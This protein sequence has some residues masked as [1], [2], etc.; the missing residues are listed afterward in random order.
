LETE[1]Q[2]S[3]SAG[4]NGEAIEKASTNVIA[5]TG[6]WLSSLQKRARVIVELALAEARLA[7]VS[8][9]WIV[10]MAVFAIAFVFIGW[11]MLAVAV[12][13][14]LVN[15]GVPLWG[16]ALG[17]ALLHIAGAAMLLWRAWRLS[18]HLGFSATREQLQPREKEGTLQ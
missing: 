6:E 2:V 10:A 12:T 5:L 17:I 7:A 13:I 8:L 3:G 18:D 15:V 4:Q 14:V 16:A 9:T 1:T 11:G